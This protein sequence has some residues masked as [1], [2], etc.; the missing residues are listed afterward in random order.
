M[1]PRVDSLY[2]RDQL[3]QLHREKRALRKSHLDHWEATVSRTGTGRPVDAIISPAVAYAACPH[4]CN[5][6]VYASRSLHAPPRPAQTEPQATETTSTPASATTSTTRHPCSRS[7]TSTRRRTGSCPR[8]SSGTTRTRR[9]TRCVSAPLVSPLHSTRHA[10][11]VCAWHG[12][13][14][15][16]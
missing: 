16:T 4:G 7:H 2:G 11:R 14:E 5:S 1:K 8:T 6:Y 15:V 3:W 12:W 13:H 9:C 10:L